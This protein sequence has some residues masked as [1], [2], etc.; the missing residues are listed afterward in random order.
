MPAIVPES[1]T[2]SNIIMQSVGMLIVI[3]LVVI[4]LPAVLRASDV[5]LA[6]IDAIVAGFDGTQKSMLEPV[7]FHPEEVKAMEIELDVSTSRPAFLAAAHLSYNSLRL[8]GAESCPI[9]N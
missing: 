7:S 2:P 3:P 1:T 5:T 9:A 6:V 4:V 8:I